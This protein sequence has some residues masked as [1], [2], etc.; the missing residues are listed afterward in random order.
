MKELLEELKKQSNKIQ[1]CFGKIREGNN[2]RK[3]LINLLSGS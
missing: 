3:D 2:A 1:E